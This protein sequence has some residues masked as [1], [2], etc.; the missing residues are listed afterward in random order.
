LSAYFTLV[1]ASPGIAAVRASTLYVT[2]GK[3]TLA[4][5]ANRL[6]NTGPVDIA[7]INQ[8]KEN[9][10]CHPGMIGGT[11]RSE[12]VKRDAQF[13]PGIEE[14]LWYPVTN[15]RGVLPICSALIV[16]GVP[17]WSEPD[18]INTSSP[19]IRW[20][21]QICP[22]ADMPRRHGP[23]ATVHCIRPGDTNKNSLTHI[24]TS[25]NH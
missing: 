22:P 16:I 3:R 19:L 7:L 4:I 23:D 20:Y 11:G 15:S 24:S 12:Q 14:L 18:T 5:I 2:V 17:C 6:Q 8:G 10:L 21:R 25:S 1:A 13:L 9:I